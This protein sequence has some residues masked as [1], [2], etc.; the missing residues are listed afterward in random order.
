MIEYIFIRPTKYCTTGCQHCFLG[1]ERSNKYKMDFDDVDKLFYKIDSYYQ[2]N[3]NLKKPLIV[4]HGGEPLLM[5][6]KWLE[7]FFE[8]F[9]N[10]QILI[11]TSLYPLFG[12][13]LEEKKV[14]YEIFKKY[15]VIV[16]SAW[17]FFGVRKY[18]N[19]AELYEKELLQIFE[20]INKYD[21]PLGI[22][23]TMTKKLL[24]NIET[25]Y[26]WLY[27]HF[28]LFKTRISI[29]SYINVDNYQP[30]LDITNEECSQILIKFFELDEKNNFVVFGEFYKYFAEI[31]KKNEKTELITYSRCPYNLLMIN[32]DGETFNCSIKKFDKNS[33]FG[34]IFEKNFE[35]IL[36]SRNRMKWIIFMEEQMEVCNGCEFKN[37][38]NGGCYIRKE[39]FLRED[40]KNRNNCPGYYPFLKFFKERQKF[41]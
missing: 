38:C 33:S 23:I 34:N 12:K 27:D 20:E 36:I 24:N 9:K 26:K 28:Y 21:I 2:K 14:F 35:D 40:G 6:K 13:N 3:K 39:Q 31:I 5:G 15:N 7:Y 11:Q 22:Y 1:N 4:L 16:G 17:D 30:E 41:V 25:A 29:E 19:S 32:P 8:K 18:K 37:I 10:Y